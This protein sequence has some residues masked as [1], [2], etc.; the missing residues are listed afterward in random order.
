MS[1]VRGAVALAALHSR[2]FWGGSI[3]PLALP[4]S[5]IMR[6]AGAGA[7][8]LANLSDSWLSSSTTENFVH[9]RAADGTSS[10]GPISRSASDNHQMLERI[11]GHPT[12]PS[13]SPSDH[14]GI[15]RTGNFTS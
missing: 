9:A 12:T 13:S 5:M 1:R 3:N 11:A 7:E 4:V 6:G 10:S 2:H 14:G 8:A 15:G